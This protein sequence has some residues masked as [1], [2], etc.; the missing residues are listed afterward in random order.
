MHRPRRIP[1]AP[2][3][4]HCHCRFPMPTTWP[5]AS[6][7]PSCASAA[8]RNTRSSPRRRR[9]TSVRCIS[10]CTCTRGRV[11]E[12]SV[13][14]GTSTAPAWWLGG[15][16]EERGCERFQNAAR[17]PQRGQKEAIARP[18]CSRPPVSGET[19]TARVVSL[20]AAARAQWFKLGGSTR[21]AVY[22]ARTRRSHRL[23]QV[24]QAFMPHPLFQEILQ[25][26]GWYRWQMQ[27][28]HSS[29]SLWE[30]AGAEIHQHR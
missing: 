5:L 26:L 29:S 16:G 27:R 2:S 11:A 21:A 8:S 7:M 9:R 12:R 3:S 20:G 25:Q 17:S 15:G 22:R 13:P 14:T 1:A 23:A 4:P 19:A 10:G 24:R 28:V 30:N 6:W 18:R